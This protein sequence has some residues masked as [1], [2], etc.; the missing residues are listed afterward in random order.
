MH[1]SNLCIGY[2]GHT[3]TTVPTVNPESHSSFRTHSTGLFWGTHTHC[4]LEIQILE[5]NCDDEKFSQRESIN[6]KF[7]LF[8]QKR[9]KRIL[10]NRLSVNSTKKHEDEFWLQV[11]KNDKTGEKQRKSLF[12]ETPHCVFVYSCTGLSCSRTPLCS[13]KV[14][15]IGA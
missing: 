1:L 3:M 6:H 7:V 5:V 9:E 13:D 2:D 15:D 8:E 11:A 10:K 4:K 14:F 12:L